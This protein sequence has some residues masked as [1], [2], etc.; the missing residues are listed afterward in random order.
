MK[1]IKKKIERHIP[2][3]E[4]VVDSCL[5][6]PFFELRNHRN[7]ASGSCHAPDLRRAID[8]NRKTVRHRELKITGKYSSSSVIKVPMPDWCPLRL[9]DAI[10]T[11]RK[12][13]HGIPLKRNYDL[14]KNTLE[15]EW[16]MF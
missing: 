2:M 13:A 5:S 14:E 3:I 6:C 12:D 8:H 15:T 1:N 9:G 16:D 11:I 10:I 7:S 4:R